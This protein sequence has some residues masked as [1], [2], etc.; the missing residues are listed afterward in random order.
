VAGRGGRR[1]RLGNAV[2]TK[3]SRVRLRP[4]RRADA[5]DLFLANQTAVVTRINADVDGNTHVAVLLEDDPA[6]ELHEWYGRFFYFAPDELERPPASERAAAR[7]V[8]MSGRMLVAG[9][10]NMFLGDDGFGPE[11]ARRLAAQPLPAAVR[12]VDYGIRGMHLAYDLSGGYDA[13]VILDA[14]PRGGAPGDVVVLRVFPD[15]IGTAELD[16]H[17]MA[18]TAVLASLGVLGGQLP[19]TY[20]VGC[21]PADVGEG[22]GLSPPV[23]AA[24]DRAV[25]AVREVLDRELHL[26]GAQPAQRGSQPWG[27]SGCSPRWS[28]LP[29]SSAR[30]TSACAS[31]PTSGAT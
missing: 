3:G 7:D 18:P 31:F 11:A 14:P 10:G 25:D 8:P 23:T 29:S 17:G 2:V 6:R 28:D 5:Q 27:P 19:S 26:A 13:L 9:V 24:V 30:C 1:R 21:E 12:I 4:R 16:A 20:V 15:D 22:I